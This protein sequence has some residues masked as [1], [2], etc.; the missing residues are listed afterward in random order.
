MLRYIARRLLQVIPTLF[1]VS[2]LSFSLLYLF[3]GDPAEFLAEVRYKIEPTPDVVERIRKQMGFDKPFLVQY[4]HWLSNVLRGNFGTSW[5]EGKPV[6]DL[7]MQRLPASAELFFAT[8]AVSVSFA[9][10]LGIISA[11]YKDRAVDHICR[12]FSLLGISIPSFWLGLILIWIFSVKLHL[13]PAF[14][15]GGIEHMILPVLTWSF[16]FM[17]IK[18][19]F[20]RSCLLEVLSQDYIVTA[21]AKG[22]SE[23]LVVLRH[24]LRNALIPIITYFSLSIHHL[25]IGS[26]MVEVVF[27]W[28]GLGSLLVESVFE[29]DF[30]VVQALVF[31][32]GV[33]FVF[34]NLIVDILY[35]FIDPRIRYGD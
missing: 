25:I 34:V 32:S 31:L 27:S 13:L 29:R 11:I 2:L 28:P 9:L 33:L 12:I 22:L 35:A 3:P 18:T 16:S 10:F 6:M 8:F 17:A 5:T 1:G 19:R 7:I 24:A 23:R 4:L 26:I 15:Y 20:V 21:R 14:G 30:P